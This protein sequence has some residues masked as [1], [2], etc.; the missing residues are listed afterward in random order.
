M[1][2]KLFFTLTLMF[3]VATGCNLMDRQTPPNIAETPP[4]WQPQS[5]I[6]HQ[7]LADMRAFHERETAKMSEDI[8]VARNREMERLEAT[9]KELEKERLWQEDYEKTVERREKWSNWFKKTEKETKTEAS[10]IMTSRIGAANQN[11][12]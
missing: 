8:Q 5:E 1:P 3:A 4:Y 10:P 11:V 7:Q 9:G 2:T 6:A 12:R